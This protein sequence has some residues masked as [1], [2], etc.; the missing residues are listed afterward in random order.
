MGGGD[1]LAIP[2]PPESCGL[3]QFGEDTNKGRVREIGF[4]FHAGIASRGGLGADS[5]C[6]Q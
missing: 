3:S 4:S 6:S 1:V 2:P 5:G